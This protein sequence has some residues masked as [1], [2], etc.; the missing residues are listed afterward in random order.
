MSQCLFNDNDDEDI[1]LSQNLDD[2]EKELAVK[3]NIEKDVDY[4]ELNLI[5]TAEEFVNAEMEKESD[6]GEFNVISTAEEQRF[7][8]QV[9]QVEIDTLIPSQTNANTRKNTKWSLNI[10]CGPVHFNNCKFTFM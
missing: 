5:S 8:T 7:Q 4:G 2:I 3:N 9:S 1:I 10:Y 6:C